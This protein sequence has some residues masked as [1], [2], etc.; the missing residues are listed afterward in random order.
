MLQIFKSLFNKKT[1]AHPHKKTAYA[2]T[3]GVFVG[4]IL[5]FVCSTMTHHCFLSIPKMINRKIPKEKF[6][7]GLQNGI[8]EQVKSLPKDVFSTVEQQYQKNESTS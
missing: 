4:E 3:G 8:L 6:D 7:F 1:T 5:I 2:V